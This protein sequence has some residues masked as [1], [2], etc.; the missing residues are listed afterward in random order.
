MLSKSL[1]QINA[2]LAGD[3]TQIKEV[4]H[5]QNDQLDL[6]YSL[7]HASL[8]VGQRSLPHLLKGSE[9]YFILAGRGRVFIN[10]ESR[11]LNAGDVVYIPPGAEQYICNEGD[12]TLAFL[13]IVAPAWR[14]E[15]EEIL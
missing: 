4:L 8:P 12:E 15:E 6:P 9:V 3:E 10:G 7:A 5:P 1:N 2:F 13:C 14:K 11:L